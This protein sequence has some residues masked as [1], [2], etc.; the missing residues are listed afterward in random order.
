MSTLH[1]VD[2][3]TLATLPADA[4]EGADAADLAGIILATPATLTR[5][6]S[7]AERAELGWYAAVDS[8]DDEGDENRVAAAR[9]A[10]DESAELWDAA[11]YAVQLGR[12]EEARAPLEAARR[13]AAEWGDD[14]A[15]RAALALLEAAQ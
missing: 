3:A 13:L 8:A 9:E 10:A 11:R 4:L 7:L 1:P 5:L 12:P 15:E 14:A 6:L 2:A